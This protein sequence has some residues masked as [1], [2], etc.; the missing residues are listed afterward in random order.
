MDL[1]P[2][3][4]ALQGFG[5]SVS[6]SAFFEFFRN[7]LR[8]RKSSDLKEFQD[9]FENFLSVEGV[10]VEAG[11]VIEMLAERGLLAIRNS[12]L[13]APESITLAAGKDGEFRFGF[14]SESR[15]DTTAIKA[16]GAAQIRGKNAAIVQNPDG[17]ISFRVGKSE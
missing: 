17:S 15:T 5:I 14:D 6:A 9:Q 7:Y 11:S 8:T 4:E 10:E 13:Y 16:R 1:T 12:Q 3:L 2:I